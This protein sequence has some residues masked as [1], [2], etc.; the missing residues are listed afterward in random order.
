MKR[1][2]VKRHGL[3]KYGERVAAGYARTLMVA[4]WRVMYDLSWTPRDSSMVAVL[5]LVTLYHG[6]S[7]F[8]T[9]IVSACCVGE[10]E[11][12]YSCERMHNT[13]KSGT[14]REAL[15]RAIHV[16]RAKRRDEQVHI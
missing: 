16:R 11:R 7:A 15:F 6:S 14:E 5:F 9:L 8:C 10:A 4:C 2:C 13:T 12:V 1:I 3:L